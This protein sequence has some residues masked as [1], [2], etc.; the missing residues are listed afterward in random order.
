MT[1][2]QI[3]IM[4]IVGRNEGSRSGAAGNYD[5]N[6]NTSVGHVFDGCTDSAAFNFDSL[7]TQDDGSVYPY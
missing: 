1:Q 6:A 3:L 5:V 2:L 7:A 4:V